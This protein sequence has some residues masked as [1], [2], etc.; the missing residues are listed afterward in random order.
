MTCGTCKSFIADAV[1]DG[2]GIGKCQLYDD[3]KLKTNS[4]GNLMVARVKLGNR[5]DCDI[6]WPGGGV[7]CDRYEKK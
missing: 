7:N 2:S 3:Y 6:F 1:G 5:F 4:L